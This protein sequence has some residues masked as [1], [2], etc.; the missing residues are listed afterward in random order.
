[1]RWLRAGVL[2]VGLDGLLPALEGGIR[3]LSE[4][5]EQTQPHAGREHA[6][7]SRQTGRKSKCQFALGN[8]V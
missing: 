7:G 5:G 1:M 6:P 3:E 2:A 8:H 4:G